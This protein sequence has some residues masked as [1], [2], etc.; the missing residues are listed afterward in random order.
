MHES[1]FEKAKAF[2]RAYLAAHEQQSLL[3]LDVGSAVVAHGHLS[4]RMAMDNPHWR[5]VGLDIEA[6]PNVDVAVAEPYD[7]REIADASVDVVVCSQVF[8]HTAFF[9]LTILEIGRVLKTNGVAFI[10]A[11]G[12]GPLHRYPVDCWRFYDDGLPTTALWAGLDVVES[13][14]QWAPVFPKGDQWRDAA[15]VLQRPVR[16]LDVET[17][18]ARRTAY[19]KAAWLGVEQPLPTI[20]P[21]TSA[22]GPLGD[23]G[24]F[25]ALEQ[26]H[27][28]QRGA[29]SIRLALAGRRLRAVGR[30]F[31]RPL[32]ELGDV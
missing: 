24:A 4:N 28:T 21:E 27:V 6:G 18:I 8:E 10:V 32:S 17:L 3:V 2:R 26:A 9:W 30:A 16:P 22:I 19:A 14:V 15:I 11:P 5:Y 1:A 31:R 12:S 29:W 23:A 13:R 20:T 25:R 7:W